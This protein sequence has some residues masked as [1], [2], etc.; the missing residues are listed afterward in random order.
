ARGS[1]RSAR[2]VRREPESSVRGARAWGK[3]RP[4]G[5]GDATATALRHQGD[6]RAPRHDARAMNLAATAHARLR[7]PR[8]VFL[9]RL[10]LGALSLFATAWLFGAITEDVVNHDAPLGTI[11]LDV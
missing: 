4:R 7:T 3:C 6:A 2:M 8:R 11:D 10:A 1:A 5:T 9:L